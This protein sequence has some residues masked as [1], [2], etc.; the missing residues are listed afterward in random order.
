MEGSAQSYTDVSFHWVRRLSQIDNQAWDELARPLQTPFLEWGWL[1]ALEDSGSI[2]PEHGWHPVHLTVHRGSKLIAAAP[3]YIKDH[4]EGELIFDYAWADAA[5]QIGVEYYPKLVG[6]SPATPS[7]AYRF[8]IAP[9]EDEQALTELMLAEIDAFCAREDLGGVHFQYI[10]RDWE[11]APLR[12]AGY[13]RWL[14][15]G[16]EWR[17]RGFAGF[18]DYLAVFNKNQRRNIRRERASV[19][20][21]GISVV[22]IEGP[23]VPAQMFDTMYRYYE[24]HNAQFGP[25]AAKFLNRRFFLELEQRYRERLVF[26]AAYPPGAAARSGEPIALSFLVAKGPRLIGRYWGT[27]EWHE[28]LH[29]EL[30]YYAPIEYAI[31][32]ERHCFDPGIGSAHKLRRGFEAVQ[33]ASLHRFHDQRMQTVMAMNIDRINM[34]QKQQIAMMNDHIPFKKTPGDRRSS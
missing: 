14:H 25:W 4:S 29:F 31:E 33:T 18:E 12:R 32:T 26:V 10:D 23:D 16:Y 27:A 19:Q 7:P 24:E 34:M 11:S 1:T 2:A 21:S 20:D 3:L 13:Q 17:N 15:Q 28:N 5:Y 22:S 8:L 6:M 9:G 30:C